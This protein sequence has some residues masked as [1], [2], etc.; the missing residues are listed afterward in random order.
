MEVYQKFDTPGNAKQ[1]SFKMFWKTNHFEAILLRIYRSY[2]FDK[3]VFF[4]F[5]VITLIILSN[6]N[7]AFAS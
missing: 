4:E 1:T 2:H 6:S 5:L 7:V 3:E